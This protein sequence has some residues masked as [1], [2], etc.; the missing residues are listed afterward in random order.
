MAQM[1][2]GMIETHGLAVLVQA[3]DAALK[4]ARRRLHGLEEGRQRAVHRVP[5]RRRGG[6]EGGGRR[7]RGRGAGGRRGGQRARHPA[8]ARRRRRPILPK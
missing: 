6:G 5:R 8:P 4:A 3:T 7:R 2:I 1:A